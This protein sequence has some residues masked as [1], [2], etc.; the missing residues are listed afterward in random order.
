MVADGQVHRVHP[1]V[2]AG[3]EDQQAVMHGHPAT[4]RRDKTVGHLEPGGDERT[5]RVENRQPT[6]PAVRI[7]RQSLHPVSVTPSASQRIACPGQ[8]HPVEAAVPVGLGEV[9]VASIGV[10]GHRPMRASTQ[11]RTGHRLCTAE[12]VAFPDQTVTISSCLAIGLLAG[13]PCTPRRDRPT[14]VGV[15]PGQHRPRTGDRAVRSKPD[16]R[17]T[18]QRSTRR[19]EVE[20]F[21]IADQQP[22]SVVYRQRALAVGKQWPR[23]A[24]P[25]HR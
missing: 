4:H 5:R 24:A 12:R 19:L 13:Q 14:A 25:G 10:H 2:E 22:T 20:Q 17:S 23:L 16:G 15:A 11:H 3:G 1:V 6:D 7:H 9:G 21:V 8:G 18:T